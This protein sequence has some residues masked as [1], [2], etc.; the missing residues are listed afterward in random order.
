MKIPCGCGWHVRLAARVVMRYQFVYLFKKVDPEV[1]VKV[2]FWLTH[3]SENPRNLPKSAQI[4][5]VDPC[6]E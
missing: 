1:V 6:V 2:G 3:P 5:R 4:L